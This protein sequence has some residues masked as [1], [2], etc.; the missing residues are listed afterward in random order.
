MHRNILVTLHT[1]VRT[2]HEREAALLLH[3]V[4]AHERWAFSRS[5][6]KSRN[7]INKNK[8]KMSKKE[9]KLSSSGQRA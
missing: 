5:S 3:C 9:D 4:C 1:A 6:Q 8:I 7:S 2:E